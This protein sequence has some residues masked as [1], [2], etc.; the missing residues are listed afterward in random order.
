[1]KC[2]KCYKQTLMT[3]YVNSKFSHDNLEV[4]KTLKGWYKIRK[5]QINITKDLCTKST[6]DTEI[7]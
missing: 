6:K 4:Y 3:N 7:Q 2:K 1:M 5:D